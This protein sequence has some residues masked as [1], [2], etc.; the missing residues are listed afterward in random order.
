MS[1]LSQ[2]KV[3]LDSNREVSG[4]KQYSLSTISRNDLNIFA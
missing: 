2:I 1:E 4:T 3:D